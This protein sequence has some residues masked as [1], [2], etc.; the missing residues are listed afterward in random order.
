MVHHCFGAVATTA[1]IVG[2]DNSKEGIVGEETIDGDIVGEEVGNEE[3]NFLDG[4]SS[5][6]ETR[7]FVDSMVVSKVTKK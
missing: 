3:T 2:V 4:I 6:Q 5:T 1:G 7:K